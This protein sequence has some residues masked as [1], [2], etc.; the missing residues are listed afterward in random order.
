MPPAVAAA[1]IAAAGTLGGA[2]LQS[3]SQGKATQA[4]SQ[5]NQQALQWEREREAMRKA[6]YDK[7]M[8]LYRQQF[9]AW[10]AGRSA[11]LARYGV[12][13]PTAVAQM[14]R[15]EVQASGGPPM[16]PGGPQAGPG[17]ELRMPDRA[18]SLGRLMRSPMALDRWSDWRAHGLQ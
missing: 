5:A 6:E 13:A 3:R 4:Q 8:D 1:G 15:P 7:A 2:A 11:L 16:A 17:A 10:N 12:E 9:D 18:M 14:G